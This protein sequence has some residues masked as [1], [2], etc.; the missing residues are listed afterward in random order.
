MSDRS[1]AEAQQLRAR[2]A[3]LEA[4]LAAVRAAASGIE[5]TAEAVLVHDL[6]GRILVANERAA[7]LLGCSVE[8]L[9]RRD[10]FDLEET[11]QDADRE[12][13]REAWLLTAPDLP[14]IA[15]GRFLRSD[16]VA[17]P[18]DF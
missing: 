15:R 7:K 1:D 14:I 10:M 6:A 9:L 17:V 13:T 5:W 18:V 12:A 2:V 16:G 3:A 8:A 11:L 4:E